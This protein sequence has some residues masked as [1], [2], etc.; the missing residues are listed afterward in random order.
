MKEYENALT[1]SKSGWLLGFIQ[2]SALDAHLA[3]FIAR[4][5][6]MEKSYLIPKTLQNYATR[7]FES[8]EWLDLMQGKTTNPFDAYRR[9]HSFQSG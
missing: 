6:D 1:G 4:M 2:P 3:V 9:G 8:E 7:I 5:Y